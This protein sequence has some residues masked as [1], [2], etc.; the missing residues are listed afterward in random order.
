MISCDNHAHID[1]AKEMDPSVRDE[2]LSSFLRAHY[3]HYHLH[4]NLQVKVSQK[5]PNLICIVDEEEI[6]FKDFIV[7]VSDDIQQL[8]KV[9]QDAWI[10]HYLLDFNSI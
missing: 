6:V 8:G 7:S 10:C 4:P 9:E 3:C 1:F 2:S 5:N